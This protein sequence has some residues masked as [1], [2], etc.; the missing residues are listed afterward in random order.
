MVHHYSILDPV[1]HRLDK[2][3]YVGK[4]ITLE[5][6]ISSVDFPTGGDYIW[7]TYSSSKA[8]YTK[9]SH[10]VMPTIWP[11]T[12][13]ICYAMNKTYRSL[14]SLPLIVNLKG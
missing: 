8:Y 1:V 5:C 3:I 11:V 10:L 12:D 7:K 6:N 9:K 2:E 13:I 14:V 4:N